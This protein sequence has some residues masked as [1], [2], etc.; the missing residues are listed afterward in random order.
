MSETKEGLMRF[1]VGLVTGIILALWKTLVQILV[2]VN[3]LIT[4]FSNKRNKDL[5]NFCEIFNTQ[6]YDFFQY[7]TF[8]TNKR[9]F[10]FN[11]L[12]VSM[13][14]FEKNKK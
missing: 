6:A 13:K 10:P 4:I 12:R 1:V 7:M 5:A 11:S 14:K 8:V 9:P 3:L 2:I